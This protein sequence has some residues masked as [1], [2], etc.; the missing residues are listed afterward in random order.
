VGGEPSAP[1]KSPPVGE[2]F[3][4][5]VAE[6]WFVVQGKVNRFVNRPIGKCLHRSKVHYFCVS[7][8]CGL[9]MITVLVIF[10]YG[11]GNEK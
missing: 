6:A 11:F 3:G 4:S 9:W 7:E 1:S 2:A 10:W 8:K 5:G